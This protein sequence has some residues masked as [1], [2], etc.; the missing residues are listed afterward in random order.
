MNKHM[1]KLVHCDPRLYSLSQQNDITLENPYF[2]SRPSIFE[3]PEDMKCP[4]FEHGDNDQLGTQRIN[5]LLSP[6]YTEG[7]TDAEARQEAGASAVLPGHFTN[8]GKSWSWYL[9]SIMVDIRVLLWCFWGSY[10][11]SKVFLISAVNFYYVINKL[12]ILVPG[13]H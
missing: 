6:H 4:K 8:L 2:E 9:V 5:A 3:D 13:P 11:V 10:E 12:I 7:S 1:E